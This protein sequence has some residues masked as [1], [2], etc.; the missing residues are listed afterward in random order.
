[1][2]GD[3][4]QGRGSRGVRSLPPA[5]QL[6]CSHLGN[7][8]TG[9]IAENKRLEHKL[10]NLQKTRAELAKLRKRVGV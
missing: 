10:R 3:A 5:G 9:A 2:A 6:H 8:R 7:G 4:P 1:M